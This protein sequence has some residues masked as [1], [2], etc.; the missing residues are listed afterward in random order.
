MPKKTF[1]FVVLMAVCL[2]VVLLTAL[3][4][5]SL[6]ELHYKSKDNDLRMIF[7]YEVRS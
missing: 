1:T 7:A 6:C 3:F 2:T 4:R 5:D